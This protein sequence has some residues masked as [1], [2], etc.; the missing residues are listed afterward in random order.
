M[1]D[2]LKNKIMFYA[3]VG[4]IQYWSW[5][6]KC[7][8]LGLGFGLQVPKFQNLNPKLTFHVV[9]DHWLMLISD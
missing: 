6:D 4:K 5:E 8:W 1:V 9:V 2:C 7:A 3:H